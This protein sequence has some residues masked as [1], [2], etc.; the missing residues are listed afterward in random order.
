MA[1]CVQD[2]GPEHPVLARNSE[3][4]CRDQVDAA[5]VLVDVDVRVGASARQQDRL[6]LAT[7]GVP[8]VKDSSVRVAAFTP[9]VVGQILGRARC[10][11]SIEVGPHFEQHIDH[12]RTG[13]DHVTDHVL[14]AQSGARIQG[15]A[16]VTVE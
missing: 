6:D 7:G 8:V 14:A 4:L 1:D 16:H 2:V 5:V 12:G 3:L 15:V 10:L 13:F 9:Q 11:F